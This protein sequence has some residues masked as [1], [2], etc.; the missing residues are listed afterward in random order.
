MDEAPVT[1]HREDRALLGAAIDRRLAEIDRR[2]AELRRPRLP[3]PGNGV[4]AEL[5]WQAQRHAMEADRH[6]R[7]SVAHTLLVRQLVVQAF[8]NAARAHQRAAEA[9]ERTAQAGI[10]DVA[11]HQRRAEFHRAAAEAD[12]QRAQQIQSQDVEA[13]QAG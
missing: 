12:R 5:L 7:E 6:W 4:A 13:E 8:E 3:L 11:E 9:D 10:G 1:S 2:L